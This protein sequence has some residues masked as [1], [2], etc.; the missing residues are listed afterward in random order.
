MPKE[1]MCYSC[2]HFFRTGLEGECRKNSPWMDDKGEG[3]FPR[4]FE[5]YWCGDHE[6]VKGKGKFDATDINTNYQD[7][8]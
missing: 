7:R 6:E 8:F 3:K 2:Q 5:K 1:K 4:V